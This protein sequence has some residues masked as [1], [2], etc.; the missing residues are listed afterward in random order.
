M[1]VDGTHGCLRSFAA[2]KRRYSILKTV[3]SVGGGGAG[4]APF[5]SVA[6]D[7]A[8][9]EQLARSAR[10]LVDEYG[11]DGIDSKW[12]LMRTPLVPRLP[13]SL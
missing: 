13:R 6:A 9:R 11:L 12:K 1:E 7:P 10:A 5:A 3:L 4:S 8:K 2:L